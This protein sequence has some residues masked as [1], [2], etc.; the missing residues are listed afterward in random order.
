PTHSSSAVVWFALN[1]LRRSTGVLKYV[2]FV[3][4][5]TDATI[6]ALAETSP[7]LRP[8]RSQR[9]ARSQSS[10]GLRDLRGLVAAA[11]G[12]CQCRTLGQNWCSWIGRTSI[13]PI[14]TDGIRDATW[15]A[16]FRSVASIMP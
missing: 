3:G 11:V 14:F 5:G 16:S 6:A 4:V 2:M 9:S 10:C 13:D 8:Q 7:R 15:I 1:H 12:A